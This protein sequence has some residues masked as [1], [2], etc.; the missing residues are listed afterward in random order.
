M[1]RGE[2]FPPILASGFRQ[3]SYQEEARKEAVNY[4]CF[5]GLPV[6]SIPTYNDSKHSHQTPDIVP[7]FLYSQLQIPKSNQG[8]LAL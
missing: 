3:K 5:R 6:V 4:A 1:A 7:T 2:I 8:S